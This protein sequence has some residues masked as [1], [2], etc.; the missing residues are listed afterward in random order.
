MYI[1]TLYSFISV[2][3][4][5]YPDTCFNVHSDVYE[6][7]LASYYLCILKDTLIYINL[8]QVASEMQLK[9]KP[10]ELQYGYQSSIFFL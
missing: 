2:F 4:M 1:C 6:N 3:L 8:K 9:F 7:S 10:K 5:L